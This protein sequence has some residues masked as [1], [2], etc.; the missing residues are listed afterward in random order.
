MSIQL[1]FWMLR[2]LVTRSGERV[3]AAARG[4]MDVVFSDM[5]SDNSMERASG[6]RARASGGQER[7]LERDEARR[8]SGRGEEGHK[9]EIGT[10]ERHG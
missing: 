3:V 2:C 7:T 4:E 6:E 9:H 5:R 10:A 1:L 8:T